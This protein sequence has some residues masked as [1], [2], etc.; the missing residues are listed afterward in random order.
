MSQFTHLH[1]ASAYSGHYGVTRPE[2]LAEAATAMGASALAITDRNGLYGAVKHIGA[3][4]KLGIDPIVGVEIAVLDDLAQPIGRATVLAHGH[5]RGAGWSTLCRLI[6]VAQKHGK[7]QPTGLTIKQLAALVQQGDSETGLVATAT[8]VLSPDNPFGR[9]ALGS[10]RQ[11]ALAALESWKQHFVAHGSLAVEIVSWLTEPGTI[12]STTQASRILDLA[13]ALKIPTVLTNAVRYLTPDDALTA[14]VL[15][16]ARGL[17]GQ[18]LEAGRDRGAELC[19]QR[20]RAGHAR[21]GEGAAHRHAEPHAGVAPRRVHDA[22]QVVGDR[23]LHHHRLAR[24]RGRR[25]GQSVHPG[26]PGGRHQGVHPEA[27]RLHR[28]YRSDCPWPPSIRPRLRT[29]AI[30]TRGH[31]G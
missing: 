22:Q 14:D 12:W 15:D 1:V 9:L 6:S 11:S 2:Y 7:K 31:G 23:V 8:V 25:A 17:E 3:C 26:G 20:A 24:R 5:N 30:T 16:A 10:N 13:D 27:Q 4:L 18:R 29:S 21:V 28:E 19:C